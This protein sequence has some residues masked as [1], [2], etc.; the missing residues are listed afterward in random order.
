MRVVLVGAGGQLAF[1]LVRALADHELVPLTRAELELTDGAAVRSR[2]LAEKPDAIVNAA[3]YNLVDK[4][5]DEPE[6]AYRDNALVP[7]TLALTAAE[8]GAK[9]IHFST[10]YVFG[11]DAGRRTPWKETDEPGPTG[12]YGVS[13]LAGEHFVR[14]HCPRHFVLRTCGVY[15]VKGSRGK[16]GNFVETMLRLAGTGKPVRV[17]ND[18]RCTPSYAKHLA[19]AAAALLATERFG[20]Y[21]L[22]NAGECSWHEFASEI[23]KQAGLAVDCQPI[24]TA[25]FGARANR[26]A[27][28]VL[29]GS[30]L[31]DAGVP[32]L[33]DWRQALAEYLAERPAGRS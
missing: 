4:A 16:G 2:M 3:A 29:D 30:K 20:L 27:Y 13:K 11:R 32:P 21:H 1:D 26:P 15:G 22:V 17:V 31:T 7:R 9:L 24:T 14:A 19:E 5:E 23:F 25:E 8:I 33:P 12:A 10:D 6:A 28:S 18:Q